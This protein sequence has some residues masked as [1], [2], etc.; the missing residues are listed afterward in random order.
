[1]KKSKKLDHIAEKYHLS[2]NLDDKFIEDLCQEYTYKWVFSKIYKKDFILELGFGEG[3]F[4]KKLQDGK[5]NFVVVEGSE[6]LVKKAKIEYKNKI[7]IIHDYFEN[8]K[9]HKKFDVI[10]ATHVLEHVD[11]PQIVLENLKNNLSKKGILIII[12]PNAES[13]HRKLSVIMGLQDSLYT[14]SNR[15]LIVGHQRVYDLKSLKKQVKS[16]GFKIVEEKGFF[17]KPLSNGQMLEYDL[18]LL[19]AMNEISEELPFRYMANIALVV[20]KN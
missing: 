12:V 17:L 8:F 4:T 15:D 16:S 6:I 3:N 14:L 9:Y 10:L 1:M 2:K 20:C 19:K 5:Y 7:N 11:D 18:N 13:I